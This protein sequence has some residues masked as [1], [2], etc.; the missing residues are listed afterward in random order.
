[1]ANTKISMF[2]KNTACRTWMPTLAFW[3]SHSGSDFRVFCCGPRS[4]SQVSNA[5]KVS[6]LWNSYCHLFSVIQ[7]C[8]KEK[9]PLTDKCEVPCLYRPLRHKGSCPGKP[10]GTSEW[11]T[12]QHPLLE[13]PSLTFPSRHAISVR[14][15]CVKLCSHHLKLLDYWNLGLPK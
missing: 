1:M 4:R 14:S 8:T 11:G 12:P 6:V 9:K 7:P 15:R 10:A 2:E 5:L 3:S 13:L